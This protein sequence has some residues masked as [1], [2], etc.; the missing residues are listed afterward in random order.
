MYRQNY[1]GCRFSIAEA[2]KERREHAAKRAEEKR[3]KQRALLQA[4]C[5][6]VANQLSQL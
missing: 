6:G 1:C 4:A 5:E 3:I 2:E